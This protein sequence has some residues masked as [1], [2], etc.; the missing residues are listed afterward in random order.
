[1]G[2]VRSGVTASC[3][4]VAGAAL[5]A[6]GVASRAVAASRADAAAMAA[7]RRVR[8]QVLVLVLVLRTSGTDL[9]DLAPLG[10]Y[11]PAPRFGTLGSRAIRV[12]GFP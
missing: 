6:A 10:S 5:L 12:N 9:I 1:M 3:D 2:Q 8:V 4:V 11:R 7:A